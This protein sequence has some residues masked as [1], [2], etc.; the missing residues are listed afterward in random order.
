MGEG[1]KEHE[2]GDVSF[3]E[4]NG[5]DVN[6]GPLVDA[7]NR[8]RQGFVDFAAVW[9]RTQ[10]VW[11]DDRRR[12]FEQE[13]L[14]ALGPSLGRL[15]AELHDFEEIVRRANHELRDQNELQSELH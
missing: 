9:K 6:L 3:R 8:F 7:D 5:M 2:R 4:T 13:H 14:Q 1:W 11:A 12:R 15:V 10:E